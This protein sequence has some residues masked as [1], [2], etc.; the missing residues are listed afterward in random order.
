MAAEHPHPPQRRDPAA[1]LLPA[2]AAFLM[3][4]CN[5]EVIEARLTEAYVR[6]FMGWSKAEQGPAAEQ[7]LACMDTGNVTVVRAIMLASCGD[8][9]CEFEIAASV[10]PS[11][12]GRLPPGAIA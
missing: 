12:D 6:R 4:D 9:W 11:P 5:S 3:V 2:L 8:G 1:A 7:L 10:P